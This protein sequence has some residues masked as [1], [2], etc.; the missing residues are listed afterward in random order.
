MLPDILCH[1][2]NAVQWGA[3]RNGIQT[4]GTYQAI[5]HTNICRV[6]ESKISEDIN[7][8]SERFKEKESSQLRGNPRQSSVHLNLDYRVNPG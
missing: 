2:G 7:N 8:V 5:H 3:H 4:F 6:V 1:N